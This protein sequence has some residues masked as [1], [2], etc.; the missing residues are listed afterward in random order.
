MWLVSPSTSEKVKGYTHF[1]EEQTK[2]RELLPCPRSH[3][4]EVWSCPHTRQC[5]FGP[6]AAPPVTCCPQVTPALPEFSY[7]PPGTLSCG[8]TRLHLFF[9][10]WDLSGSLWPRELQH[11]SLPC[12][13]PSPGLCLDSCPVN[14]WCCWAISSSVT[15]FFCL[16]SFQHQ[17]LF[18]WVSISIPAR[19]I[20]SSEP[21]F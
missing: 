10:R 2:A 14:R 3:G 21:F 8:R 20:G 16:Q 12:P 11:A 19:Q 4:W 18:Q 13:S 9:S 5:G 7:S 17:G 15:P 6:C 1:T